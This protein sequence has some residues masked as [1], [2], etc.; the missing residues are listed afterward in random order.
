[1]ASST[2][3]IVTGPEGTREKLGRPPLPIPDSATQAL[4]VHGKDNALLAI[5]GVAIIGVVFHHIANRRFAP[6]A[7]DAITVLP[8]TFSWC[9]LAFFAVSGWLHALGEE[10]KQRSFGSFAV[11]RTRR[12]LFPFLVI[13]LVYS[14]LWQA[15]Q[16]SGISDL[17]RTLP[18]TLQGKILA[19]V[20][21][22]QGQPVGEQL[23]FMPLLFVICLSVHA[24]LRCFHRAGLYLA[25]CAA[26]AAGLTFFPMNSNTGYTAGV[27]IWGAFCYI[28]GFAMCK[29]R[30]NKWLVA[31]PVALT[32]IIFS[33]IGAPGL[34]KAVPLLLLAVARRVPLSPNSLLIR[35]G[36]ASG[37]IYAYH[38]PFV[39][40]PLLILVSRLP[41]PKLQ[42]AGSILSSIVA[43][44]LCAV[45][46]HKFRTTAFRHA[47]L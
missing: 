5:K 10:T 13:V 7:R 8:A 26:F 46:F 14:A 28:S 25:G 19:S 27:G 34:S 41:D 18:A 11:N 23:Y 29:Q 3:N 9:V 2:K 47:L 30:H 6:D 17:G 16:S 39:L 20:F 32:F 24:I 37:T 31:F 45:A 1:M 43:M 42:F 33:A 44:G 38:S 21:P 35:L 40:Y 4:K 15:I 36:E 12:L 22:G